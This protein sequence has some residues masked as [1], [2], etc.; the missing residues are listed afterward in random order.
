MKRT[1]VCLLAACCFFFAAAEDVYAPWRAGWAS[2]AEAS[3]PALNKSVVR[4]VSLV[5]SVRD[6]SAFQGWKMERCGSLDMYYNRSMKENPE[7]IL[8]F[9]KHIT[10]YFGFRLKTIARTQD[11]P[12][13]IRFTF[14]EVPAELNTPLDPWKGGLSRAW[15]QDEVMT[16]E[17]IDKDIVLPRRIAGRFMKIELLGASPDFDFRM[18]DC[19]FTAQTS[20]GQAAVLEG[21]VPDALRSIHEVSLATLSECMQTVYEDGPKRDRRLWIGDL[22]LEALANARSFRNHA[23]TKRCLYLLASLAAEDGRL[24]ANVFETPVPHPQ[25]GS[26]T[27]DYSLI[28]NMALLEYLKE[29]GDAE[30]V[31]DLLPVVGRQIAWAETFLD[32]RCIFDPTRNGSVWLVFDW[33]AGFDASTAM[34]GLMIWALK[35]SYELYDRLGK[36]DDPEAR[37]WLKLAAKMKKAALKYQ[38]DKAE[39]VFLSGESAQKS[40]LSQVWMILSG[41]LDGKQGRKA[42]LNVFSDSSAVYPGAPYAYHYLIQACVDCGLYE[43]ARTRLVDY[44]GGMVSRGADTYWEVYDPGNPE[45][46]PYGFFPLNSYC[47]AWSCTPVYFLHEYP[48]IFLK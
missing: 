3:I 12:L 20:A 26:H 10:G 25:Y 45:L 7:V 37:R 29:T 41:V 8:D 11:A 13:R 32:E 14:G 30:T 48:D 21:N 1:I 5:K 9:G 15:M 19:W 42:L 4:P 17:E 18:E 27:M 31:Q 22:Y 34:Q 2:M 33:R 24:H 35:G 28:Y 44:W 36:G 40:Y 46:S 38:Y 47:H 23:L 6:G 43:E 16:I 39:G